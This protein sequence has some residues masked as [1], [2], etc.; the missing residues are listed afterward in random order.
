[1]QSLVSFFLACYTLIKQG[2][3]MT[4]GHIRDCKVI[5]II[6]PEAS[7]V[8]KQVLVGRDEGWQDNVMRVFEIAQGGF[9]AK[10]KHPWP[11]IIYVLEGQGLLFLENRENALTVGTFAYIPDETLHQFRNSAAQNLKFI[12]VVPSKGHYK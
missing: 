1:M 3:A 6:D 5:E 12:C 4:I 11:H 9:T 2:D 10:H 8:L 7:G